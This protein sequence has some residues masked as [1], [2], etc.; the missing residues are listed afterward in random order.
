M[1]T[2]KQVSDLTGISV[3][4]LHYYD[5]IGLLKPSKVSDAGYRLY[6]DESLMVL[7]Q[8]LFYKELDMTLKE[9][10][11][12]MY[13]PHYDVTQALENQKKLLILK[14]NRLNNLVELINKTLKGEKA[15][16]FKEFDMSEYYNALEEF[17]KEHKDMI[18]LS[19]GT[20]EKYNE[21]IE[22]CKLKETEIAQTAI[23]QYGSIEKY[24]KAM[25]NN[26][27]SNLFTVAEQCDEFRKDC[28]EDRHPKL[29]ELFKNIVSDLSK[30][31]SSQEI[32]KIAEEITTIVR[33][34]Y[35]L[36]EKN[37]EYDYWY[38]IVQT[39][40]VYPD[41]IN[42]V[43][44][45]YGVGAAKFIGEALNKYLGDYQPKIEILYKKLSSDLKKDPYSR[46]IQEIV[47]EIV[48]TDQKTHEALKVDVG[49]NY[50][51]YIAE[52]YLSESIMKRVI[53]KKYGEGASEFIGEALKFYAES[54]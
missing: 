16:S 19:Y 39:Y 11:E 53:N 26:F 8:I 25:K 30:D 31:P 52:Q 34:D 13:S 48:D 47:K 14:S 29:K 18:I 9:V 6:D 32:Q 3:R 24:V 54:R 40:L 41:W 44:E 23:K 38:V 4:M 46:E 51:G 45:K 5:E 10:K 49:E 7:Q 33:K 21:F 17:K 22:K 43:D 12:I 50:W 37:G 1:R 36:F 20:M 42:K 35:N 2:V 15:M 27:N 28:L